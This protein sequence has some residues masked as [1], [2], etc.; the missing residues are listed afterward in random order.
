MIINYVGPAGTIRHYSMVDV[1][2]GQVPASAFNGKVVFIGPT[3]G[4][5]E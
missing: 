1:A 3:A 2:R 4:A 5:A